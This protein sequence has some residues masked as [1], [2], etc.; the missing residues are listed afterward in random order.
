MVERVQ[1][2]LI[3]GASGF[4]GQ[5]LAQ[6]LAERGTFIRV[7]L[8]KSSPGPWNETVYADLASNSLPPELM[9]GIDTVFHLAGKVH[10]LSEI[11]EDEAGYDRVNVEG[12]K[13]LLELAQQSG[14]QAFIYFSSVK[15]MGEGGEKCVDES[16]GLVPTTAYGR[17]KLAAENL[18][19]NGGYVPHPVV[20]RPAMVYGP[21]NK[22]NLTRMVEAVRRGY[23]PPLPDTGNHRS[24]VHVDDV[25][26]AAVL[27]AQRCEAI[28]QIYIVT[29]GQSYST[30]QIYDWIRVLLG[31]KPPLWHIPLFL[32]RWLGRLG[33][34]IGVL[35]GRR[36]IF[37][38][39]AL[40]KMTGSAWYD[41][42]RLCSELGFKPQFELRDTLRQIVC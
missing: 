20:L 22:G 36:F 5:H 7:L 25:V 27:A 16:C 12:T 9:T 2:V 31:K 37:D 34:M 40:E 17:S 32:L 24:M 35:R 39:D 42:S 26:Q 33:D 3:T 1:R 11:R 21:E 18:V 23:F 8:R 6:R 15:A 13:K 38:S 28:G 10:A 14:V 19:L 30:R 41:N 29:D 4:I